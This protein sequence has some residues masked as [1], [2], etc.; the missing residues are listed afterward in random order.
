TAL[1]KEQKELR[2]LLK[3]DDKQSAAMTAELRETKKAFT[4]KDGLGQRRTVMADAPTDDDIELDDL[5]E[6]EP[7]TV[8]ISEKGWVRAMKGHVEDLSTIK[9]KEGDKARFAVPAMTND[10]VMLFGTNGKFFTL[11]VKDLPGGRGYGEPVRL[12]IDLGNEHDLA[13]MFIYQGDR[14]LL[15]ASSAGHGL[16]VKEEDVLATTKK[17]KQILNLAAGAEA[18]VCRL[19]EEAPGEKDWAASL[20]TN[21]K[22]VIFPASELPTMTKGKGVQLQKFSSGGLADAKIFTSKEGL[23]W[24]DRAGRVQSEPKWRPWVGKRAQAGKT[25]PKGF[26]RAASFGHKP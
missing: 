10:K 24:V 18:Q 21:R 4:G 8:V 25:V 6:K 5:I 16:F 13:E 14:T 20:G 23:T 2:A 12:M 19:L 3:S 15:L 26:P 22:L 9:Y 7:V 11:D 1:K 17:G